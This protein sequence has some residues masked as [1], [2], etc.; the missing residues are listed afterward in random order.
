M[1]STDQHA[2]AAARGTG[3]NLS[4][5][6]KKGVLDLTLLELA[7][8]LAFSASSNLPKKEFFLLFIYKSKL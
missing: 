1:L 6:A 7:G 4:R 5:S 3:S 2:A 8:T